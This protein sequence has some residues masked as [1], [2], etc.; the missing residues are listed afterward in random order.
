MKKSKYSIPET[1]STSNDNLNDA[2]N[3]RKP[4]TKNTDNSKINDNSKILQN[5]TSLNQS[6]TPCLFKY[7]DTDE[8]MPLANNENL[9][10]K[11][12]QLTAEDTK[13]VQITH[14]KAETVHLS[15]DHDEFMSSKEASDEILSA[16]YDNMSFDAAYLALEKSIATASNVGLTKNVSIRYERKE[17][18]TQHA[19]SSPEINQKQSDRQQ[20]LF[21]DTFEQNS[22]FRASAEK[23]KP[24]IFSE[25]TVDKFGKE[26]QNNVTSKAEPLVE[27]HTKMDKVVENLDSMHISTMETK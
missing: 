17:D 9:H 4:D 23:I 6:Q 11:N 25:N 10:E 2:E 27:D 16:S 8:N 1:V 24:K 21:Q 12:K 14:E 3:H 7:K 19:D 20:T 5:S 22:E 15:P 18:H 13:K 26:T